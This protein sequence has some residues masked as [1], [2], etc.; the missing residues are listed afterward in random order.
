MSED[1][2]KEMKVPVIYLDN[3]PFLLL[4]NI[5]KSWII[6]AYNFT[7]P[8]KDKEPSDHRIHQLTAKSSVKCSP[9][10]YMLSD[11]TIEES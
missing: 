1:H 7:K 2:I 8:V 6:R 11:W 5:S 9:K 3:R 10:R 4:R